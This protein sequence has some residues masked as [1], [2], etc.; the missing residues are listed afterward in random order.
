MQGLGPTQLA[1]ISGLFSSSVIRELARKE[2]SPLF[3]RLA[4]QSLLPVP[5]SQRV[6]AMFEAAFAVLRREGW[7]DEYIYKAALTHNV[8][9]GTH[10]L[11]TASMLSEFRVGACKADLVILNGTATVYEV[12]SERDSLARLERQ[13]AAYRQVFARVCVI[14]AGCHLDGVIGSV[15]RDVGVLL[16]SRRGQIRTVRA[17]IDQPERT[18]SSAIF[19]SVRTEEARLILQQVGL[20]VPIVP[21]TKLRGALYE[22]F[23]RLDSRTAHDGMV[24]VLKRTRNL[25]PLYE[26]VENLPHSLHAAALSVPLRRADHARFIAAVNTPLQR[27]MLWA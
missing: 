3:A 9:L 26:M 11:N 7:R 21:N 4:R 22:M 25:L 2:R 13:I 18:S 1:A 23:V 24:R 5:P 10:T 8:L 16:L 15:P 6:A 27:A 17:A 12:K 19:E 14:T 20:K